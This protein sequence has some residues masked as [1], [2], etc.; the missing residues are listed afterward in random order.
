[1]K[2]QALAVAAA[3]LAVAAP[4]LPAQA[5]TR[6]RNAVQHAASIHCRVLQN[7]GTWGQ[8]VRATVT[9]TDYG[10]YWVPL[11]KSDSDSLYRKLMTLKIR[12][13]ERTCPTLEARA[14]R[15]YKASE[16]R[17]PNAPTYTGGNTNISEDP[18]EF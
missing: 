3:T 12:A 16:G 1:M 14:Y 4:A 15:R 13:V 10:N 17:T 9:N 7:G 5:N 11:A 8:A 18:F 6:L 2:I